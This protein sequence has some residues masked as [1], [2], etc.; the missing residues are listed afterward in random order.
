MLNIYKHIVKGTKFNKNLFFLL[1]FQKPKF[2]LIYDIESGCITSISFILKILL[3]KVKLKLLSNK[4][5]KYGYSLYK[6]KPSIFII[7]TYIKIYNIRINNKIATYKYNFNCGDW[8]P[9]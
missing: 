4:L 5:N 7:F 2:Y 8:K 6:E 9:N 1:T 3:K